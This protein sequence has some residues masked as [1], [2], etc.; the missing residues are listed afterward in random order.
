MAIINAANN[1]NWSSSST[2][3]GG[4]FPTVSDDVFANNRTV[5]IDQDINVNSLNT[6]AGT[7]GVAGGLFYNTGS[8]SIT[9]GTILPGTTNCLTLTGVD[10]IY[11]LSN[12]ISGSY[13]TT[14]TWG[15]IIPGSLTPPN[16][17]VSGYV[18]GGSFA[19]TTGGIRQEAG[20]LSISGTIV[21]GSAN[22]TCPGIYIISVGN[23][24]VIFTGYGT[25]E[26]GNIIQGGAGINIVYA[27]QEYSNTNSSF[28]FYGTVSGSPRRS[29]SNN[30][31]SAS[32]RCA[33]TIP[34]NIYGD[35]IG[36]SGGL[37][38]GLSIGQSALYL[39][40]S[41]T[42]NVYGNIY[43][44]I[45]GLSGTAF[46]AVYARGVSTNLNIVGDLINQETL[47]NSS[48]LDYRSQ[49]GTVNI[50]GNIVSSTGNINTGNVMI[51]GN[52][53][54]GTIYGNVSASR[55][56]GITFTENALL[57]IYGDVYGGNN[58]VINSPGIAISTS[59][60]GLINV[61]GTVTP[62]TSSFCH[63]ISYGSA[64]ANCTVFAKELKG[65]NNWGRPGFV[66]TQIARNFA[67]GSAQ[68]VS[69]FSG[70]NIICEKLTFG[71]Y[72]SP[73]VEV[74]VS[75]IDTAKPTLTMPIT[76][77]S[78]QTKTLV[79]PNVND[80]MPPVS[81]VRLGTV[82]SG[83]LI[84]TCN[85]PDSQEVEF[86]VPVDNTVGIAALRP[87][88]IWNTSSTTLTS[89]STTIGYRL[90]NAATSETVGQLVAAFGA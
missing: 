58:T 34:I 45:V 56:V 78:A 67:V 68:N 57:S 87:T 51:I 64:C 90:N 71:P 13:S 3:P 43:S 75:F 44:G 49:T 24:P 79:D 53:C 30:Q 88:N 31:T 62:G 6:V 65:S 76:S 85:I 8:I 48:C 46:A 23:F 47:N 12:K 10:N 17:T 72:G 42:V 21:G 63:G 16:V 9:A 22:S 73:P 60:K 2:W 81:S 18:S 69:V 77:T 70:I 28:T 80:I 86:G 29:N 89:L 50:T 19:G 82:Y 41:T 11:I 20:T 54:I 26:G 25:V 59:S 15:V 33:T 35:V 37:A 38:A 4:V 27:G 5:Y 66:T 36:G 39:E 7:G 1:G 40:G 52:S 84:G 83:S 74:G 32:I 14:N 55:G 61:Y